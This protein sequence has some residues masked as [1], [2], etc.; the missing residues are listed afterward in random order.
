MLHRYNPKER[1]EITHYACYHGVTV[2]GVHSQENLA[3]AFVRVLYIALKRPT[4]M[5]SQ[6]REL[7]A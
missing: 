3:I 2:A 4:W 6:N 5:K 1:L 7:V